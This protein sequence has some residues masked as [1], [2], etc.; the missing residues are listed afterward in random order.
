MRHL[1]GIPGVTNVKNQVKPAVRSLLPK[2][3]IIQL[4]V[5]QSRA[6]AKTGVDRYK[7]T[8]TA[9]IVVV[10][11]SEWAHVDFSTLS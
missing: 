4:T 1:P 5:D 3:Q 10:K 8:V 7:S 11:T 9:P 6:G 2:H